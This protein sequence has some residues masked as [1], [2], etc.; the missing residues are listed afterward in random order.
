MPLDCEKI[1]SMSELLNV[2]SKHTKRIAKPFEHKSTE[3]K[4]DEKTSLE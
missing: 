1:E 2:M 3:E 4:F